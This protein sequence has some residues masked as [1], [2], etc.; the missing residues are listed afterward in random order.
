MSKDTPAQAEAS[1]A[2]TVEFEHFD[3]KWHVPSSVRLSHQRSLRR[4][5]S[6]IGIVETFLPADEVAALDEI[7]PTSDEL[8]AFTDA[9]L[10][11]MGL[12][13]NS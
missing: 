12:K 11:A 13:G 7:D 6:N 1:G 5:P 3:K 2:E 8:D 9:M 4:D 10:E